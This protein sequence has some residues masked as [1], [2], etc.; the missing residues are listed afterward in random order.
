MRVIGL[1]VVLAFSLALAPF[2]ADAPTDAAEPYTEEAISFPSGVSRC[3][4]SWGDRTVMATSPPTSTST[5]Q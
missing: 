1:A 2:V 4:P 3:G 5:A